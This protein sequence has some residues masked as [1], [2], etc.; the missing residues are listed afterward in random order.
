M[1]SDLTAHTTREPKRIAF[2][3]MLMG[4]STLS[5]FAMNIYLPSVDGMM[6]AFSA[7]AAEIQLT[8]AFYFIAIAGAQILLGPIS[9]QF[10][11]RPVVV[12]GMVL[13]VIGSVLCLMAPTVEA[14]IAARI[15]QAIGGG[16]G[17]VL[18]RAIVRDV[19]GRDKAASMIGYVAMG[20]AVAPT[21]GPAIGGFLDVHYGWR[22]GF[23]LMLIFGIG[24]TICAWLFLPETNQHKKAVSLK[25]IGQGYAD[26]FKEKMF[27]VFCGASTFMAWLYFAYLGGAPFVAAGVFNMAP[28]EIG[29]YLMVVSIGYII[30]NFITGRIAARA[31]IARMIALG[32]ITGAFGVLLLVVGALTDSLT[33]PL[34][35]LPMFFIGLG[36][37]LGIPS[38]ISG[39]VSIRPDLAGTA[40]GMLSFLQ[41]GAGALVSSAVAY[42]FSADIAGGGEMPMILVM[43]VGGVFGLACVL[44]VFL[45]ERQ[46]TPYEDR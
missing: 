15:V 45:G 41:V 11:R 4:I 29:L 26:L 24:V 32:V 31:G 22:G 38:A 20:M 5:P 36:N 30:G 35:F 9:D 33:G 42:M 13:F 44:A 34:F 39:A 3:V 12:A 8:L 18:A 2:V 7:T 16:A 40:S 10:G 25:Q 46:D 27:W 1:A 43:V 28:A 14:L 19:Y 37:G 23:V 17:L 6:S 21:I